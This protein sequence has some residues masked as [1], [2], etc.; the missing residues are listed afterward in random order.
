MA[1]DDDRSVAADTWSIKSDYGSTLDDEQR[2]ADAAS[3]SSAPAAAATV[4]VAAR[5]RQPLLRF[6][7]RQGSSG[8][9]RCGTA[10]AGTAELS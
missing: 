1:S 10:D 7:L 9:R 3:S 4:S 5:Q 2:Y 8:L 6:Q